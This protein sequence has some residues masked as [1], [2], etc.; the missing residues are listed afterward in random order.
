MTAS[1][2]KHHYATTE[3]G[4]KLSYYS[5]GS[6]PGIVI[7]HGAVSYAFTH[8]ELAKLLSAKYTVYLPSRRG[9]GLSGPYPDSVTSE[10]EKAAAS[11]EGGGESATKTGSSTSSRT[12]PP[13]L[14]KAVIETELSD[15]RLLLDTTGAQFVIG[16][17]SGSVLLLAALMDVKTAVKIRKAVIFEPPLFSTDRDA[18][19][20]LSGV[21][22]FEARRREGDE[23]GAMIEAMRAVQLGPTWVPKWLM[24]I[25][26]GS[27]MRGQQKQI[28]KEEAERIKQADT[29]DEGK[30]VCSMLGLGAMLWSD[31]SMVEA[32]I[33]E[34]T[35]F[36]AVA[37]K[38]RDILLLNSDKSPLYLRQAIAG[39]GEVIPSAKTVMVS[40]AGHGLLCDSEMRGQPG[41]AVPVLNEF[42]G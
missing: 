2:L 30:G 32:M 24:R 8:S 19:A 16:D 35:R 33:G 27:M 7:V 36:S 15:L 6:G 12:Y 41:K 11:N 5:I 10:L 1:E 17:S 38:D 9:R 23:I 20:D 21:G 26:G 29:T 14:T 4:A 39:L 22:R 18:E 40:G 25:L 31:F 34:C 42:F 3:D 28:E 37:G 13:A